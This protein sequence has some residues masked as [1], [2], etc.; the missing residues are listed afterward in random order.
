MPTYAKILE[1]LDDVLTKHA[2]IPSPNSQQTDPAAAQ[3]G[4]QPGGQQMQQ[5]AQQLQQGGGAGME[6]AQPMDGGQGQPQDPAQGQQDTSQGQGQ[7]QDPNAPPG[8]DLSPKGMSNSL[9]NTPVT[10]S[11]AELLDLVSG[12]K[13]SQS[14][15]KTESMKVQHGFKHKKMLRDEQRKEQEEQQKKQQEQ[16]M[17]QQQQQG[18]M[19]GGIYS[20]GSMDGS[21]P[22]QAPQQPGM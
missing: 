12:G 20:G 15:L 9:K 8:G 3:Q 2:F 22:G 6:G 13:A 14:H 4:Q 16:M 21:Q 18:M 19:G 5:L 10:V 17:Q 11:V 7:P 1:E